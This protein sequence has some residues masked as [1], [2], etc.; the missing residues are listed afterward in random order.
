MVIDRNTPLVM[1]RITRISAE[2]KVAAKGGYLFRGLELGDGPENRKLFIIVPVFV[3]NS[4]YE[5]PL[6]CWEGALVAAYGLDFNNELTDG[7]LIFTANQESD[8]IL[9]PYRPVSVTDAVEAARC[10]KGADLVYRVPP[11]EPL[12]ME[13]GR[14]IHSLFVH[15]MH[16]GG[17]VSEDAFLDGYRRHLPKLLAALPGSK[18]FVDDRGLEEEAWRHF[19]FMGQWLRQNGR[20]NQIAEIEVDRISA[21]WGLKGRADCLFHGSSNR[22]VLELKTGRNQISDH[23][24]QLFAY[25][26]LFSENEDGSRTD[27]SLLYSGIAKE[28]P[29]EELPHVH[30]GKILLGRNRAVFLKHAYTMEGPWYDCTELNEPCPRT[31]RCLHRDLCL[32][33]YGNIKWLKRFRLIGAKKTYYD[34]WFRLIGVE[35][36]A[37]DESFCRV[38][39]PAALK[40]RIEDGTTLK[41]L[42]VRVREIGDC[43]S[44][45]GSP[46]GISSVAEQQT[47]NLAEDPASPGP[48]SGD[49][50]TV[51]QGSKGAAIELELSFEHYA[52]DVSPGEEVIIHRGDACSVEAVRGRVLSAG[53]GAVVVRTRRN[54]GAADRNTDL[55]D[56]APDVG[57]TL[58]AIHGRLESLPGM[59]EPSASDIGSAWYLDKMPFLRG[60]QTAR[61]GLFRFLDRA[62]PAV[63]D[64]VIRA[65]E[66][67]VPAEETAGSSSGTGE[68]GP[69]TSIHSPATTGDGG[70]GPGGSHPEAIEDLDF[71]EGLAGELNDEQQ[72]AVIQ[73]L[74]SETYHLIHGPPGTGKTRVLARLVRLCLDRG[75]RVLV[76]CPTNVALDRLL[77]SLMDLGVLNFIRVGSRS[78]VSG[79]FLGALERHGRPNVLLDELAGSGMDSAG[80]RKMVRETGLVGATAY[81]TV[82]HPMFMRQG[83]DRVV[84]DEAGQLDE[85]S[86]LGP[87]ALGK[88]F[89]LG[90]DHLQL[91]PVVLSRGEDPDQPVGLERSLFERLFEISGTMVSSLK[92]QYRMNR[93]VQDIPSRLFYDGTLIPSAEA[94]QRRLRVGPAPDPEMAGILD[95]DCPVVFVDVPG[96]DSGKTSPEEARIVAR[97]V[98]GLQ[99]CGV[100][101]EQVGIITPYKAQQALIRRSLPDSAHVISVDTVDRF[102]GGEREVIILS[103]AR[104]DNVTSFL[105]DRKRLNVS[106]SRARS[107]LIL[108]GHGPVLDGHPLFSAILDGLKRIEVDKQNCSSKT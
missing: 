102:Q 73:A 23:L 12:W 53:P 45:D 37:R 94:A 6:L 57:R 42:D 44:H 72:D 82:A 18:L 40:D 17:Q 48:R 27:G 76:A 85:P 78:T 31:A 107:K 13:K 43:E 59:V 25:T 98:E 103:L 41:V 106:L 89:V 97:I 58:P 63:I 1:G 70:E 8:L 65:K 108:L 16:G 11:D 4:L 14:M 87:L 34:H 28:R 86:T 51:P 99:L 24:L 7:S 62:R 80:F 90:G 101:L 96:Q 104:S 20:S 39:D 60:P 55:G 88:R 81:Q 5:F 30:R 105:A 2:P 92:V 22:F 33:L 75:E 21:R 95:P 100:S 61:H 29:L 19:E 71:A 66:E 10:L 46:G 3:G 15:L 54:P 32:H 64:A 35:E 69:G 79:E 36:W 67:D 68:S 91:P 50:G 38:L 74:N 9:E 93:A 52:P 47:R 84:V 77:I 83:F 49:S 56:D 26:L